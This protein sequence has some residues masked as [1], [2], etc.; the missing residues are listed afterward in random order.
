[1]AVKLSS[2]VR[3]VSDIVE[4]DWYKPYKKGRSYSSVG[5]GFFIDNNGYIL[6]C[7]HVVENSI[8]I[9]IV[10]PSI[11]KDKFDATVISIWI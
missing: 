1:M 11:G 9:S 10:I 4:F 3:I 7:A 5:T 6:T 8:K 2:L